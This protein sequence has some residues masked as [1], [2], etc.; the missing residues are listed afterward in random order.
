MDVN[1]KRE[2]LRDHLRR[3]RHLAVAYSGGVDSVY[4]LWEATETL[5][6]ENALGITAV[7]PSLPVSEREETV[8]LAKKHGFN[9]L[10]I[11]NDENEN[12]DYAA[13]PINRCYFC[14]S[15]LY[16]KAIAAARARGFELIASGAN[17]DDLGD[18]RPATDNDS[19]LRRG[20]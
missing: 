6:A 2:T 17:A 16:E 15:T 3:L 18:W 8:R 13:N 20:E 4:L 1:A 9:H 12:P 5:G 14:K 7:S 19:T 10:L 11:Q